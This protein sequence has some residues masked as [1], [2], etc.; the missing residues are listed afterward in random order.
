MLLWNKMKPPNCRT[1][2]KKNNLSQKRSHQLKERR[3]S[4]SRFKRWCSS[5]SSRSKSEKRSHD[6]K[7]LCISPNLDHRVRNKWTSLNKLLKDIF[8]MRK[9]LAN[10]WKGEPSLSLL[11]KPTLIWSSIIIWLRTSRK[12]TIR[13]AMATYSMLRTMRSKKSSRRRESNS[14]GQRTWP[15]LFSVNK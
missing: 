12:Q 5:S 6:P 11:L 8:I 7:P 9:T 1:R 13:E 15:K 10:Y 3:W 2:F 14:R 4:W